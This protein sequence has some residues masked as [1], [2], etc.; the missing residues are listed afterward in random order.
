MT[1][2]PPTPQPGQ[3][4]P[5]GQYVWNG[6]AWI[7]NPNLPKPKKK[8][9]ALWVILG[10]IV[11]IVVLVGGCL[12]IVAG[13]VNEAV[14]TIEEDANK[15][16]GTSNPLPVVEGEAFEVDG[17]DYAAGWEIG[18]DVMGYAEITN[19]RVTNNRDRRDSAFVAIKFWSGTEVLA[20]VD[21]STEPINI[22]TTVTLGCFSADA[23]PAG[24]DKVT[25][26]DTF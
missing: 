3:V 26:N 4:S 14:N 5:D 13:G 20:N 11:A 7:S 23:L 22:G 12:A 17:F 6:S 9:T 18:S 10:I 21:C 16:G 24:Y 25:I 1:T 15:P 8:H 19:L 2:Q